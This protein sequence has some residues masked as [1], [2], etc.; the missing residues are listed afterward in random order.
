MGSHRKRWTQK[1]EKK[2]LRSEI[3]YKTLVEHIPNKIFIKDINS[4]YLSCNEN[5]ADDLNMKPEDVV[6]KTDYDFYPKELAEK[7]RT[8]DK[9]IMETG[10]TEDMEEK[11]IEHEE[12]RWVHTVKTPYK[13]GR[14]GSIGVL[15]IFRDITEHKKAEADL[16]QTRNYLENLL[17]CANAPIVVWDREFKITCFNHA[18]EHLTGYAAN[19]VIGQKLAMLF[20]K[21]SKDESLTQI[22][23]TLKGEHWDSVEIPILC[24]DRD[25]RIALWNSANVYAEDG[26]TL[27]ATI[28]QGMDITERK[29]AEEALKESEGKWR[30]LVKNAPSIIMTLDR[31]GTILFINHTVSGFTPEQ[32]IGK[33]Q[34]DFIHPK[35]RTVVKEAIEQVFKTGNPGKYEIQGDGTNGTISW[36]RTHVGAI[37]QDGKIVAVTLITDDIT[38]RKKAEKVLKES[39]DKYRSL[40]STTPSGAAYCKILVD[41]DN[42]PIDFVHLEVNNAWERSIGLKRENVVGGKITEVIPGIKESKTDLIGIYG[43]VAL[44]GEATNFELYF[45]PLEK[46]FTISVYCPCKGYFVAVFEDITKRKEVEE[47][48]KNLAKFP[49]ED[50]SPVYRTSKEGVLLYANPASRRLILE[51][52]TKIGDKIPEKWIGMIRNQL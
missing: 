27:L 30:S 49:E 33:N 42:R 16:S 4:I 39:E 15:G 13:N 22:N 3:K 32:V 35:Y 18:F 37:E 29:K 41:E 50:A 21:A 9:R 20:S 34:Y 48:I 17:N 24:K 45:E 26:K 6:G 52:R 7:Y 5:Y 19:E 47:E 1:E 44:T 31:K 12:E 14:G 43:R 23:C 28:A 8:D 10:K 11:Y 25:T 46:W 51:D 40:F 38:E 36:Y 2:F